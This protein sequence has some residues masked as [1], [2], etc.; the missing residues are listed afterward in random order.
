MS[1]ITVK[2]SETEQAA[3]IR[4][5]QRLMEKAYAQLPSSYFNGKRAGKF[6]FNNITRLIDRHAELPETAPL[7]ERVRAE[8]DA[9]PVAALYAGVP[10]C[11]QI[12]S[13]CNF[14]Y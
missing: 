9:S 12:C 11:D 3:C 4:D 14:A 13:F 6:L 5:A 7:D 8:L 1:A 10:W 2:S